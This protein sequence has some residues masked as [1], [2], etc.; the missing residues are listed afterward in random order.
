MVAVTVEREYEFDAAEVWAVFAD[1]GNVS[2]VPGVEKVELEGEGIGMIRHLTV[3]VFPPLQERLEA[4][5]HEQMVLEYSIPSV[6]YIELENYTA[7][8][9]VADLGSGRSRVRMTCEAEATGSE[10]DATT[11][12]EAFYT[13]M[14][15]WV[16]DYLKP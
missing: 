15:G 9:Q 2:W 5:D 4:I 8:A 11:K 14:L 7:R 1:F 6:E 16:D 3:P 13:A 10:Q 12:T